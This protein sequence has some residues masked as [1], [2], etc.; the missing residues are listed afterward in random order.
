MSIASQIQRLQN[1]KASIKESIENKGVEVPTNALLDTYSTYIDNIS[2][3]LDIQNGVKVNYK[4]TTGIV[5]AGTFIKLN[6]MYNNSDVRTIVG[7]DTSTSYNQ[8]YVSNLIHLTN[9]IYVFINGLGQLCSVIATDNGFEKYVNP[10]EL[11]QRISYGYVHLIKLSNNL[12]FYASY[13][14]NDYN[15]R[16]FILKFENGVLTT[17]ASNINLYMTYNSPIYTF[18]LFEDNDYWYL[19]GSNAQQMKCFK[20][21]KSDYTINSSSNISWGTYSGAEFVCPQCWIVDNEKMI[22]V[23]N[24][25]CYLYTYDKNDNSYSSIILSVE[26]LGFETWNSPYWYFKF[27]NRYFAIGTRNIDNANHRI[28]M[29]FNVNSSNQLLQIKSIDLGVILSSEPSDYTYNIINVINNNYAIWIYSD[30]STSP[31]TIK[32]RIIKYGTDLIFGN[33]GTLTTLVG[34]NPSSSDGLMAYPY[35]I[36]KQLTNKIL[37]IC[38]YTI[39]LYTIDENALL[40]QDETGTSISVSPATNVIMGLATSEC[41]SNVAGDV[42]LLDTTI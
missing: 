14:G 38:G 33:E 41:T 29:E 15:L 10:I 20:I 12:L 19:H 4:A 1:A 7:Q 27:N 34:T 37:I 21:N 31:Y 36:V 28:L 30:T 23:N 16:G 5:P 39:G 32:Y 22:S 8:K 40:L 17:E 11:P 2:G 24:G 13:N 26:G 18:T 9:N 3:G 6:T 35:N 42:Y 25:W